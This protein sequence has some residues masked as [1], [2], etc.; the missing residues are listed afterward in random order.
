MKVLIG[1]DGSRAADAALDDLRKAGL[2]DDAETLVVSVA[3]IW[4]P[5]PKNGDGPE[6]YL[7][8][9]S[10]EWIER[11]RK[12][13]QTAIKE[14]ASLNR[15]AQE[16]LRKSFPGWK[17][18]AE[19]T[20]C[21]PARLILKKAKE[22]Q[23]DLIVVGSQG[24]NAVSRLFLGSVSDKILREAKC[25]VRVAREL[26]SDDSDNVRLIVAFDGTPGSQAAIDA[27]L[28][29][30]WNAKCEIRLVTAM[31]SIVPPSIGRFV[32][33]VAPW[34]DKEIETERLWVERLA[35]SALIKLNGAGFNAELIVK[36]G[37][38]KQILAEEAAGWNADC[39]SSA[40][41]GF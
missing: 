1:Y 14:I 13:K 30:S 24:R 18:S 31:D 4:M 34:I 27:V 6:E 10:P 2:P 26:S 36:D 3:E 5:P 9:V 17:I 8:E 38:P 15:H 33:P 19:T 29:R 32:E 20:C 40:E 41:K 23:P 35:E 7:A 16:V 39:C 22:F 11:H 12:L 28:R 25:S 21:S 37:N